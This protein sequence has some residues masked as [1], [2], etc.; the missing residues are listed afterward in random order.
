MDL[1]VR[2]QCWLD[3]QG[4]SQRTLARHIGVSPGAVNA[5]VSGR[6]APTVAHLQAAT[7]AI[8]ASMERF[9]GR[10]FTKAQ[11]VKAEKRKGA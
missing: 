11:I 3:S 7:V 5:W 10:R 4:I 9:Y 1:G 8:G 2:L 6:S